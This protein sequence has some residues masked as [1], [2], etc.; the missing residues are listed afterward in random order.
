MPPAGVPPPDPAPTIDPERVLRDARA[1][2]VAGFPRQIEQI[3]RL[4]RADPGGGELRQLVHRMAGFGG[5]IGLP[6]VSAAAGVL[7]AILAD[8]P[9]A[10][11]ARAAALVGDLRDAFARDLATPP[12][13][14][15]EPDGAADGALTVLVVEDDPDQAGVLAGLLGIAGHR[16]VTVRSGDD[17]LGAAREAAPD[18]VLLDVELPGLD[19]YSV[20]RLLKADPALAPVPVIFMTT[21]ARLDERLAGLTL[22][23]DEYLTKPVDVRELLLRLRLVAAR[24]R[25]AAGDA[26]SRPRR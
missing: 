16:A 10:A 15:H 1:K 6:G 22:G 25:A 24:G 17:A 14:M 20:C 11:A 9:G 23:A 26:A 12:A 2:F 13:W 3:E 7:E 8:E 4:F 19:G 21:R 5:T 18:V